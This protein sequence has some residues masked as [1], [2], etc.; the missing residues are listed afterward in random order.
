MTP[1]ELDT[2]VAEKVAAFQ[3]RF[4]ADAAAERDAKAAADAA[5]RS[6][7]APIAIACGVRPLLVEGVVEQARGLF[8]LRDGEIRPRPGV[9][10]PRDPLK[11]YEPIEWLAELHATD[12]NLLFR[13]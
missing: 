6:A 8:E 1:E 3:Q 9:M 11:D 10:H 2:L 7:I 5:F 13:K 4:E 12:D